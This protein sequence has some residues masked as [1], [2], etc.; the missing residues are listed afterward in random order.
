MDMKAAS[1]M[2]GTAN[3]RWNISR[4]FLLTVNGRKGTNSL[5]TPNS[6][7]DNRNYQLDINTVEPMLTFIHGTDFRIVTSYK[8][9]N[10]KNSPV[11]GGEK[12]ASNS[13]M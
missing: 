3:C 8:Y 11:F 4:S 9:E 12:S 7:F 5:F 6:Q 10:K 2:T 1:S 13:S